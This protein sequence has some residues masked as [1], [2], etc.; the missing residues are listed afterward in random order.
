[1]ARSARRSPITA[2]MRGTVTAR[3]AAALLTAVA[4][5]VLTACTSPA[6]TSLPRASTHPS[7]SAAGS[8]SPSGPPRPGFGRYSKVMIIVESGHS[9]NDILSARSAAPYVRSLAATYGNAT[10]VTPGYSRSCPTLPAYLLLTSGS[11]YNVCDD[12]APRTH[13]ID[14]DNIFSQVLAAGLEWRNYAE[15]AT[16]SCQS[17]NAAKNVY[18]VKHV[19]AAYYTSEAV[20][21]PFWVVP[22]G[23]LTGGILHADVAA[24]RL[25]SYA[26]VSPDACDDMQGAPGCRQNV[27]GA[28][29][30]WLKRWLP[31]IMSGPDYRAGRLVIILTWDRG[32]NSDHIPT[33]V[34]SP[35]TSHL[36]S[37]LPLTHCSTLRT[38]EELLHLP[39]LGC[40]A[41]SSSY[42]T[43]FHL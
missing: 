15:A 18:V 11:T 5:T 13:P 8:P 27:V 41:R 9:Y 6:L 12:K 34:I 38:A 39:Y 31:M 7:P 40:A 20:Q 32:S 25:P 37:A 1:M 2:T 16:T 36:T 3:G 26:F 10:A 23:S 19:P 29:D 42:V 24:G 21:C 33:L 4:M 35:T 14:G 43:A 22:M 30:N 28:G 17:I